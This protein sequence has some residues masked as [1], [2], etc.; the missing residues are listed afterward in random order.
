MCVACRSTADVAGRVPAAARDARLGCGIRASIGTARCSR[1]CCLAMAA[2]RYPGPHH[3]N[4]CHR[5]H[6]RRMVRGTGLVRGP[7]PASA[8]R[9]LR[10]AASRGRAGRNLGGRHRT[11]DS[12]ASRP[13][14]AA[15]DR[16]G[17]DPRPHAHRRRADR[18]GGNPARMATSQPRRPSTHLVMPIS[19]PST[20]KRP[21]RAACDQRCLKSPTSF[22]A[23]RLPCAWPGPARRTVACPY[24]PVSHADVL[25]SP[26]DDFAALPIRANVRH[27]LVREYYANG[28]RADLL[29]IQFRF[30]PSNS[31]RLS[32]GS[33]LHS[34]RSS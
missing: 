5:R 33:R 23:G 9:G 18:C 14:A 6:G 11:A 1:R 26:S 13:V 15:A 20:P 29:V 19:V 4:R 16:H 24:S 30:T 12:P 22:D 25:G 27:L 3:R 7:G 8:A 2:R 21:R 31:D 34:P 28:L 32:S 17:R 10:A